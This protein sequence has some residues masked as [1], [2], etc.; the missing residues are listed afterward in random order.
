MLLRTL[1]RP[2]VSLLLV[3]AALGAMA[4]EAAPA[5]AD[6]VLEARMQ[7]IAIELRCLV[8]QNQTIAD[9]HADLAVDLRNQVREMLRQGKS[10]REIIDYMT[11]RYGDFVLY[12]PPVKGTTMLLWFGPAVLLV[13]GV[14]IL[15]LVLRRRSRRAA[16]DFEPDEPDVLAADAAAAPPA[17]PAK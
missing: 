9:S 7:A 10:D 15:W 8:C 17:A 13:G 5:A 1:L 12:R 14:G 4:K 6:P 2:L 3:V 11:A 16:E